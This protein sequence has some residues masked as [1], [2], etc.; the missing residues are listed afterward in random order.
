M[1]WRYRTVALLIHLLCSG[2]NYLSCKLITAVIKGLGITELGVARFLWTEIACLC[3]LLIPPALVV[4]FG[5]L[6]VGWKVLPLLSLVI[7]YGIVFIFLL[8][9]ANVLW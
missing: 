3:F 5:S 2:I 1:F 9:I 6:E 8:N 7:V 4:L